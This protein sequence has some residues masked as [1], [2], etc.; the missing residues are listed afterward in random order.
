MPRATI[1]HTQ[2]DEN[3]SGGIIEDHG[4]YPTVEQAKGYAEAIGHQF[5][6]GGNFSWSQFSPTTW[7]L[8]NGQYYTNI[9]VS[10]ID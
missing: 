6:P 10:W 1:E 7:G 9:L 2:R 4:G 8:M 5:H 3:G